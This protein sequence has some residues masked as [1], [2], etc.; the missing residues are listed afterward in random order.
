MSQ[1]IYFW[2]HLFAS[3]VCKC[4]HIMGISQFFIFFF[5]L[6]QSNL[7][8]ENLFQMPPFASTFNHFRFH[9][10]SN[11]QKYQFQISSNQIQL[12]YKDHFF[13]KYKLVSFM[14]FWLLSHFLKLIGQNNLF[15]AMFLMPPFASIYSITSLLFK[16][17]HQFQIS[18]N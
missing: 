4:F 5:P 15:I 18:I 8:R 9:F 7:L 2:C 14:T 1:S 13:I 10:Y 17:K 3:L 12:L 11:K 6:K 16:Q